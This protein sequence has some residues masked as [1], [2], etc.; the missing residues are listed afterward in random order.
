MCS[1][2]IRYF[3]NLKSRDKLLLNKCN[4]NDDSCAGDYHES[5]ILECS[6]KPGLG[7]Q[8]SSPG[9]DWQN[10]QEPLTQDNNN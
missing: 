2:V 10:I 9:L 3:E 5:V 4:N 1:V 6:A 8:F 7:C